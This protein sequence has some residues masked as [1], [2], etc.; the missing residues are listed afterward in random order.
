MIMY[1][2]FQIVYSVGGM[3]EE[4][5]MGVFQNFEVWIE[6]QFANPKGFISQII[7]GLMQG[8]SGGIAIVLP[9]L[10]PFWLVL[11]SWRM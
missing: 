1:L 4:P 3:I 7:I 6:A 2:F 9:Y 10:V 11:A 5:M 8:I